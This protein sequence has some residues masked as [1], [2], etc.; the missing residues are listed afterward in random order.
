MAETQTELI[1]RVPLF[2]DLDERELK[3]IAGSMKERTFPAGAA[4]TAEGTGGVGFFIVEDGSATVS[5][6]GEEVGRLGAGDYFGE[7]ALIANVDRTATIT[8]DTDLRCFGMTA[9]D[10][11]P[12]VQE[13]A[14]IA[15]KLLQTLGRR[16]SEAERRNAS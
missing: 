6:G 8:A 12:L 10:F 1:R 3:A 2:S 16:L 15:W 5:V 11:R 13:H 7:V 14:S 4:V 9:W